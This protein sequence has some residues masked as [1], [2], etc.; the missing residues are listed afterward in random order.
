MATHNIPLGA[1][2]SQAFLDAFT[3]LTAA[4]DAA[5]DELDADT[6]EAKLFN[7]ALAFDDPDLRIESR[8]TFAAGRIEALVQGF[9]GQPAVMFLEFRLGAT[10][11][12]TRMQ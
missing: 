9:H 2:S 10:A 3:A 1:E 5:L 7:A 12:K 8:I 4:L 6:P 11:P